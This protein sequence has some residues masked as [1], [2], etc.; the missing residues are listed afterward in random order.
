M[1]T[2]SSMEMQDY[3]NEY[4]TVRGRISELRGSHSEDDN[5]SHDDDSDDTF[6]ETVLP[7]R[8]REDREVSEAELANSR[9][10]TTLT[11]RQKSQLLRRAEERNNTLRQKRL[12][13]KTKTQKP[14]LWSVFSGTDNSSTGTRSH[15]SFIMSPSSLSPT[16]PPSSSLHHLDLPLEV[17]KSRNP[18]VRSSKRILSRRHSPP[19]DI[20]RYYYPPEDQENTNRIYRPSSLD[21]LSDGHTM[22]DVARVNKEVSVRRQRSYAKELPRDVKYYYAN[23]GQYELNHRLYQGEEDQILVPEVLGLHYKQIGSLHIPHCKIKEKQDVFQQHLLY[24]EQERNGSSTIRRSQSIKY[25][26]RDPFDHSEE[27]ENHLKTNYPPVITYEGSQTDS[28]KQKSSTDLGFRIFPNEKDD[29]FPDI[30]MEVGRSGQTKIEWLHESD[31]EKLRTL[32]LLELDILF[33]E[34][35]IQHGWRKRNKRKK[36]K[37]GRQSGSMVVRLPAYLFNRMLK[38]SG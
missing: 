26:P 27:R 11:E 20:N 10:Y 4:R 3:W 18:E 32:S 21:M 22:K 38:L 25:S 14:D 24:Q 6:L 31:Q 1:E 36:I 29:M 12:N 28:P 16:S 17:A 15:H 2:L 37:E 33:S 23:K 35:N 19:D 34:F 5:R 13:N 8:L 9:I 30:V 7:D